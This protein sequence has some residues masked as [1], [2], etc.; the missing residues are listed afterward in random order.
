M[1]AKIILPL[2]SVSVYYFIW[3]PAS[4]NGLF[5]LINKSASSQTLPGT[6]QPLRTVYT[7][8][9]S[10]DRALTPLTVFFWA[11]IDGSHPALFL[12]TVAFAGTFC[13]AWV[14]V[15]LESWR[16]G[17]KR[18]IVAFAAIFG[19]AAQVFTYAFATPLYCALQ[20]YLS[21]TARKPTPENL[22]VPKVVLRVLPLTFVVGM[23]LPSILTTLP[24]PETI[25]LETKQLFIAV[26]QPWPAYVALTLWF[27]HAITG[28]SRSTRHLSK[29]IESQSALHYSYAFALATCAVSH[30]IC[31]TLSFAAIVAPGILAQQYREAFHPLNV[32]ETLLP[33]N[34][35][36]IKVASVGQG[37]HTFL[38]WDY[39]IGSTG[40]LVWALRLHRT[41]HRTVYGS[42]AHLWLY[43][44]IALLSVLTGPVGA[45]VILMWRRDKIVFESGG[46][47]SSGDKRLKG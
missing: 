41:A 10:V 42:S 20:T 17:N 2:L 44:E 7:G 6:D 18:T 26:W 4:Q 19:L 38:R 37:A 40:V 8:L 1:A 13:S 30:L 21:V 16:H 22:H 32:F 25:T 23:M 35:S 36:A 5:E 47:R 28:E 11:V 39:L 14:L 29:N 46:V 33:W 34:S 15:T 12:H 45:A 31:L 24:Y 9:D 43:A 3:Q 27:V